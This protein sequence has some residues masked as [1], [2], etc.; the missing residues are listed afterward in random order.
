MQLSRRATAPSTAVAARTSRRGRHAVRKAF[1]GL[2]VCVALLTLAAVGG[3][4][5]VEHRLSSRIHQL[6]GV[7]DGLEHRPAKPRS[8]PAKEAVNILLMG[9]DRR[10]EKQ[11]TGQS[12]SAPGWIPGA[13]RTDSIMVLHIDGDRRGASVVSVPRDAWVEVPGHG[14]NK[15]NAAF[16]FAGPSLAV[17]TVELLTGVRIDH[18][19]VVD[20]EGFSKLTDDL[21]G[22]SVTVPASVHDS[23][24]GVTWAAGE[25]ELDG[26]QALLYVRQRYG[27]PGG[28]LDR[29]RRQHGFLKSLAKQS[30][31]SDMR[32][33]PVRLLGLLDTLTANLTV[34][35]GWSVREM[36]ALAL[37]LRHLRANDVDYL[38]VP[39]HGLGRVGDQ[40]VVFLDSSA[41]KALWEA[42]GED[43]VDGWLTDHP[44]TETLA[45]KIR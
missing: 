36:G 44:E 25:H 41:G 19:A 2:M 13:Q 24:R 32:R 38:T 18:L 16:S 17:E 21:G 28:D 37:S 31:E 1:I 14:M 6:D 33:S 42:V 5:Y 30:F 35:A 7:F 11:T 4:F 34:D 8:G 23:A 27:L 26:E 29:I 3:F 9:T 40:S 39:V 43:R 45:H 12:A 10:S 22:V 15:V 20:W